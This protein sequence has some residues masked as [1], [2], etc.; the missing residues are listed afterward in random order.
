[1]TPEEASDKLEIIELCRPCSAQATDFTGRGPAPY[2]A[3]ERAVACR[4][5][6]G[7]TTSRMPSARRQ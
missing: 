1:V 7:R 4:A 6:S 5:E 3:D 2:A